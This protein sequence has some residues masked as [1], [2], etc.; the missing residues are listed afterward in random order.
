MLGGLP[1]PGEVG[2]VCDHVPG[3]VSVSRE[4]DKRG[5]ERFT[6]QVLEVLGMLRLHPF[7]K[8]KDPRPHVEQVGVGVGSAEGTTAQVGWINN[9][10]QNCH[11]TVCLFSNAFDNSLFFSEPDSSLM[12][13]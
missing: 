4:V 8:D 12:S 3:Q 11:K 7:R 1:S 6:K 2:P 13:F 9:A 5:G 10:S